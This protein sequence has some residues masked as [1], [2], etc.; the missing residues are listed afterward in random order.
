MIRQLAVLARFVFVR[1]PRGIGHVPELFGEA[2]RHRRRKLMRLV[3]ADEIVPNE[4]AVNSSPRDTGDTDLDQNTLPLW[5]EGRSIIVFE[6][7]GAPRVDGVGIE[8]SFVWLACNC[9]G[10]ATFRVDET[11]DLAEACGPSGARRSRGSGRSLFALGANRILPA[12]RK[13]QDQ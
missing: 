13:H 2:S 9:A 11:N 5:P 3:S 10:S 1:E 8:N 4:I 7:E 6:D 12:S